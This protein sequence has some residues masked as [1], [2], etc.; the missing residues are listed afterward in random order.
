MWFKKNKKEKTKY[1]CPN[2]NENMKNCKTFELTDGTTL[3]GCPKCDYVSKWDLNCPVPVIVGES[4]GG[5]LHSHDVE[6]V[7]NKLRRP[8]WKVCLNNIDRNLLIAFLTENT[9]ND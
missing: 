9:K 6:D 1:I 7:L 3:I 8:D 5:H 4:D 2:C